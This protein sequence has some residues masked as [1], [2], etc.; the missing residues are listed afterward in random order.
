MAI[1]ISELPETVTVDFSE[2]ILAI[3][4]ISAN[5]TKKIKLINLV[6][7]S[8]AKTFLF[9]G[10]DYHLC[11]KTATYTSLIERGSGTITLKTSTDGTTFNTATLPFSV[12]EGDVIKFTCSNLTTYKSILLK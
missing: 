1:K 4:D 2:D 9:E 12:E 10:S 7:P 6:E 11:R 3:V 5:Q 8:I